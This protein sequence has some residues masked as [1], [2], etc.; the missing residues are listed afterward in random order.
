MGMLLIKI[1]KRAYAKVYIL[2]RLIPIFPLY[3]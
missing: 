1:M 3:L 2:I